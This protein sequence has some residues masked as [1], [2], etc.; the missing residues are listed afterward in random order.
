MKYPKNN[1][2]ALALQYRSKKVSKNDFTVSLRKSIKKASGL[3]IG[4][5][6]YQITTGFTDLATENVNI[7]L[8]L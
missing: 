8:V 3:L 2:K 5:K 1:K 4:P 7:T 6:K